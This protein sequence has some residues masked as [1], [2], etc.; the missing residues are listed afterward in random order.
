MLFK[1]NYDYLPSKFTRRGTIIN[2]QVTE[3]QSEGLK[4]G[5]TVKLDAKFINDK[6]ESQLVSMSK[7]MK[8]D[9]FR[10][11]HVP[12]S[13]LKKRFGKNVMGEVIE[14]CVSE[15]SQNVLRDKN[16]TPAM[17]PKIEITS[18]NEGEDLDFKM[19]LEIL[20]SVPEIDFSKLALEKLTCDIEEKEISEAIERLADKNKNFVRAT[21]GAK[22]QKG[23]Q[24]IIDFTGRVDGVEFEGGA[25][26]KFAL[27]LGSGNF[28]A[29]FEDQLVGKKEGDDVVV[30]VTFPDGYHKEDLSG[31]PAEFDVHIHEINKGEKSEINDEFAKKFGFAD[32]EALK[33][34]IKAQLGGD[35]ESMARMKIKKQLFDELDNTL[36]FAVPECMFDAEFKAIWEKLEQARKNGEE[37]TNDKSDDELRTEYE[38]IAKRRVKLGIALSDIAIK[39]KIQITQEELSRAVMQQAKQFPGQERTIFDFY[40]KNPQYLQELRGPIMEEKAVDLIISKST[41][42]ERKVS[43]EEIMNES[44]D[45][46]VK[47]EKPAKKKAANS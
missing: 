28:I 22:A 33:N 9:G 40:H 44:D 2:M 12:M 47:V 26:K 43:Q 39:N 27:E 16:L 1:P 21:E 14:R 37:V 20:P 24:A 30:K 13:V 10:P 36:D 35:Y 38:N 18:F 45:V 34:A 41:V 46:P 31:K 7:N 4:R 32:L 6:A 17:S 25:A 3:I 23:D 5:Y 29:G 19:E 11:G 8:I 42:T 15:S